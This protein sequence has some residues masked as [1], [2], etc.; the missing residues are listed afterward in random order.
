[1]KSIEEVKAAYEDGA[2]IHWMNEGYS[3][4]KSKSGDWWI[5]CFNG[6][7]SPLD[8]HEPANF[9]IAK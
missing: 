8:N 1:M 3:L 4:R 7:I 9:F 5:D 2:K 6:F